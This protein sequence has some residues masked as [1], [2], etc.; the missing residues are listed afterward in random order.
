MS[1]ATYEKC[2][3]AL[4]LYRHIM[5]LHIRRVPDELRL[6][7]KFENDS[8][9]PILTPALL[10]DLYVKQEFRLHLDKASDD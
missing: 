7:G 5:K 1:T 10:G 3:L 2:Q 9:L 8:P 6:F 4:R